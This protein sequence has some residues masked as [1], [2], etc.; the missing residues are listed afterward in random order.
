MTGGFS[1][2]YILESSLK[3][4]QM[5]K[6]QAKNTQISWSWVWPGH[7]DTFLKALTSSQGLRI[8]V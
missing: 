3:N 1:T 5:P 7:L 2:G 8:L 4:K 6:S